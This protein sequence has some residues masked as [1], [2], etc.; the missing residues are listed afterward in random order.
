MAFNTPLLLIVWRR[1]D[2]VCRLISK[3]R[4]HQ[5]SQIFVACDGAREGNLEEREKV[6]QTRL[7]VATEIDCSCSLKKFYQQ[8]T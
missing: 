3:L 4:T 1:P 5:P 7:V 6:D 2:M 8:K